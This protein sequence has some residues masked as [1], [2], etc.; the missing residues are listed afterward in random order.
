[1]TKKTDAT[2]DTTIDPSFVVHRYAINWKSADP[3]Y[4]YK[5]RLAPVITLYESASDIEIE[6]KATAFLYFLEDDKLQGANYDSKRNI[7]YLD[8]SFSFATEVLHL[9]ESGH[10]LT[11]TYK[12]Q[13]NRKWA[14]LKTATLSL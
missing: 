6:N 14:E 5:Y 13:G 3:N 9:I 1:M 4:D 2:V 10:P 7:Y 11:V 8:Y 12:T